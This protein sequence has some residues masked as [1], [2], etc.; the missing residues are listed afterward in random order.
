VNSILLKQ[1]T[2]LWLY[3]ALSVFSLLQ[4]PALLPYSV[5][6]SIFLSIATSSFIMI[7]NCH[8]T[9]SRII[10]RARRFRWFTLF[11]LSS[12]YTSTHHLKHFRITAL[13]YHTRQEPRAKQERGEAAA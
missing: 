1:A 10:K 7:L 13:K 5:C 2:A 12:L 3:G 11:F 4:F 9:A 6:D 8:F